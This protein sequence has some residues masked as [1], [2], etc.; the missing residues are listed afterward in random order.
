MKIVFSIFLCFVKSE[1]IG[2]RIT[3]GSRFVAQVQKSWDMSP[4]RP[5][6]I[7]FVESG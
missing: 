5:N 7:N 2:Q 4:M 6:T 3:V 1:K